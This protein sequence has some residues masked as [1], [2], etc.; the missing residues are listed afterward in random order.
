MTGIEI[1][2][3]LQQNT[4]VAFVDTMGKERLNIAEVIKNQ[5]KRLQGFIR[6]R[7][8]S[9]EDA[10]DILQDVFSQLVEADRL[11]KPIDQ[12]SAWLFTVARNRITDLYRKKKTVSRPESL[13]E[14][15]EESFYDE[16]SELLFDNGSTPETEYLRA[17]VW[18]E[19]EKAMDE[20]PEEQRLVFE[21]T[22][23]KGMSFKAIAQQTGVAVNT[24]ISRKRYA[25][26]YLRER[27]LLIYDELINF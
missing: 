19:L 1:V 3:A 21:L 8:Q 14:Y 7:V 23:M 24:L 5:G 17:L 22:E 6:K 15:E 10:D 9:R 4:P 13:S 18:T 27:L 25:V 16:L 12:I 11:M 2:N 20:L 26:L